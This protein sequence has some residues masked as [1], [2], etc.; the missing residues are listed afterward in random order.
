MTRSAWVVGSHGGIGGACAA[1]LEADGMSVHG[2]DAPEEDLT[3]PGVAD[4]VATELARRGTIDAGVFAVG[5]SGRR[6][7]DGP[8]RSC[9]DEGWHEVMRVNLTSAFAFLR[10][11]LTHCA[12]GASVV[13][14]GSALAGRLDADFL[15]AAYRASKA[16]MVAL[17]EMAAFEGAPNRIR[18][19]VVSPGLVDTPMSERA[20]Y[21][22]AI[23]SRYRALMPLTQSPASA[24]DVAAAVRWLVSDQSANTTGTVLPVDGGWNLH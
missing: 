5:M 3:Q 8:I 10:A 23:Q 18:V 20:R 22:A 6:F 19:N 16:A 21:S 14:I 15:T 24:A 13:L 4:A 2:S 17:A 1:A 11:C 12:D 9:T 7:G